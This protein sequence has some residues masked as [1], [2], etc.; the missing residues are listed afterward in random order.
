MF[1]SLLTYEE[2][3]EKPWK[4]FLWAIVLASIAVL[5][6]AQISYRVSI[7]GQWFNL[8]GLF[9]VLFVIIP[10][11]YF[12]TVM[13]KREERMEEICCWSFIGGN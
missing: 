9:A 4:M 10:S 11:A 6:S 12:L 7:A 1:E 5:I 8:S 13:I 3:E 2:V